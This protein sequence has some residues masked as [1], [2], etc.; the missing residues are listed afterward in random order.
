MFF[1][2]IILNNYFKKIYKSILFILLK[3]K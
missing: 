1:D 2:A 3:N